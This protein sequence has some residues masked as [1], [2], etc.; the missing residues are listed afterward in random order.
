M[1]LN[2]T[3]QK[4]L[5]LVLLVVLG[6]AAVIGAKTY[7]QKDVVARVN[8]ESIS[9]DELYE[10]MVKQNGRQALEMLISQKIIDLEAKKQNIEV[11]GADIENELER[12]YEYYG[13]KES[14][15]QAM[16]MNGYSL[17]DIKEELAV[18]V[19]VK[20]LLEP[21]ISISEEDIKSYFEQNKDMFEEKEQ[22]KARHILVKSEETA[23]EVEKKLAAGEDFAELAK[24]YSTDSATKDRGGELGYF[25]KGS[26]V[27]EFEQAAF[28]MKTG[29]ISAP[30]KSEYGYHIIEVEDRKEA[31]EASLEENRDEIRNILLEQ[32]MQDEY[33]AWIQERYSEY[34]IENL[35]AKTSA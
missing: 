21:R 23:K 12:L 3:N 5:L 19:K 4:V 11:S 17:D 24:T 29:E 1:A 13:G 34:K 6:I 10:F 15:N 31:K 26:M 33:S 2:K 14:F 16:E 7:A 32:K 25:G 20:K 35:L 27:K 28:S 8:G 30:V 22:V 9:K 18:N